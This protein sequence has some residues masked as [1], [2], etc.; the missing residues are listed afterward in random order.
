M[1][2]TVSSSSPG[3]QYYF[4]PSLLQFF[5]NVVHG[6][7]LPSDAV[8]ITLATYTAIRAQ[9]MQGFQ[10]QAGPGGQ[11]ITVASVPTAVQLVTYAQ[12]LAS[13]LKSG[14][15]TVNIAASGQPPQNVVCATD[16]TTVQE[17]Q[18]AVS[19]LQA[20]AAANPPVDPATVTQSYSFPNGV[21]LT[22]TGTQIIAIYS[23]ITTFWQ[24]INTV[25]AKI[26][27]AINQGMLTTFQQVASPPP[28][29]NIVWPSN[30]S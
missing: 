12:G 21:V 25:V 9:M 13:T 18:I 14:N 7:N 8:Q 27:T 16:M 15:L 23:A 20:G 19:V 24:N 22:L 11:P 29:V 2:D 17:L 28:N 6:T 1:A 26:I 10:V 4:S 3:L 30:G 5:V